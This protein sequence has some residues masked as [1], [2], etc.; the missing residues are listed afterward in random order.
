VGEVTALLRKALLVF[1]DFD[2]VVKDSVAAKSDGFERLFLPYGREVAGRVRQHH[3]AHG[4]ISRYEKIPIYLRWVGEPATPDQVQEFCDRFGEAVRQAVVDAEWVPGIREYLEAHHANQR[5]ILVT[6][7]PQ[8]EMQEILRSLGISDFFREVHGAP[9]PKA[10]AIRDVLRRWSGSADQALVIGDSETDLTAA[11]AN[12]IN[13]LLRCTPYNR[14]LQ[15]RYGGPMF[16]GLPT[17]SA[18]T[19]GS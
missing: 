4:G 19:Y 2:G 10:D 5:F 6:A 15:R 1:W 18:S 8:G 17:A 12:Q 7:T 11:S 9:T 13:F 14:Q 16:S 3:E